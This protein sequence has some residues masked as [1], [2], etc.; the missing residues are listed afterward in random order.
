MSFNAY[1]EEDSSSDEGQL[2]DFLTE[3]YYND[4]DDDE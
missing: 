3:Q 2:I 1:R 4:L